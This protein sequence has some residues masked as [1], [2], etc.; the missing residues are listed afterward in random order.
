VNALFNRVRA[1]AL[2]RVFRWDGCPV[3]DHVALPTGSQSDEL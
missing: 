2:S 3:Q 1:S